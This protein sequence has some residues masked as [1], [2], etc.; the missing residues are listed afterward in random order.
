MYIH[1][2]FTFSVCHGI[3]IKNAKGGFMK[4]LISV[5]LSLVIALSASVPCFAAEEK[6]SCGQ[7]PIIYVAALGSGDVIRDEGT[8]NRRTLFRPETT[9]VLKDFLPILPAVALLM[10]TNNYDAFGDV[11]I[12]C[13]NR[14]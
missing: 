8:E 9:D 2:I 14:T 13:V 6:C 11:L 4:K 5:I 1:I 3:L 10:L 7:P 12:S